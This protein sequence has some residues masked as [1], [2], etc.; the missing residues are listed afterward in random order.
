MTITTTW[1]PTDQD[2]AWQANVLDLMADDGTW[3]VPD[4]LS[5]FTVNKT[6]KTFRLDGDPEI[7]TNQR[8]LIV[9][10][11]LGYTLEGSD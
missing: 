10:E 11:R 4:T 8:I 1:E 5:S 7:E 3:G 9:F 2:I 6:N